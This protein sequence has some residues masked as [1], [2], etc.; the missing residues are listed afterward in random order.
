MFAFTVTSAGFASR[1][2]ASERTLLAR[3]VRDVRELVA[4]SERA[5]PPGDDDPIAHLDFDP[6]QRETPSDPAL[7]RLFAPMST[8]DP[9]LADELRGLT[10]DELRRSKL[11]NLDLLARS[12]AAGAETVL[13]RRGEEQ[14][15]LAALTDI[16]LVLASRLGIEDDADSERFHAIAVAATRQAAPEADE[17]TTA[18][19]ALYSGLTWWQESLLLAVTG[20]APA[21]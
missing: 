13:V 7:A 8:S 2:D 5:T 10:A 9:D 6:D 20:E 11:A 15:W 1:V 14:Q 4:G 19:A 3:L 18:L 12:L 21:I 16:R 17:R